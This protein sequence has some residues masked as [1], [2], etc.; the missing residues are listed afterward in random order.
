[1]LTFREGEGVQLCLA[2]TGTGQMPSPSVVTAIRRLEV[3]E[4]VIDGEAVC[5]ILDG[6][7]DIGALR[8][9]RA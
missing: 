8:S 9:K 7:P 3:K 5:P 4:V 1:M 2:V 6:R